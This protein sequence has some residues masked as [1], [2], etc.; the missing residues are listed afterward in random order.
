MESF[1]IVISG[2]TAIGKT[3]VGVRIAQHFGTEIISADS[4][5]IYREMKIG[6]A[7]PD[8]F[9][10]EQ[11]KHHFIH[12]HSISDYYNASKFEEEAL[13]K[14]SEIFRT[15]NVAVVVGG[16]MLYIDALCKGID[17]L[18][19]IDPQ[20][21]KQLIEKFDMEG[22][23]SLRFELKRL[24]PEYYQTV[25]LK[26]P[27]RLLHALEICIMTGK[28]YSSFRTHPC[29]PRPF[30]II[31]IGLNTERSVLY[32]RINKRVDEMV[33]NGLEQEARRLWPFRQ[34]NALNTVGYKEWFACF[35]GQMTRDETID[36]IKSNTRRYARKQ[37]TWFRND[38]GINW[39]DIKNESQIIPFIGNKTSKTGI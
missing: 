10:L 23:E 11:V 13:Q 2:P 9:T 32:E 29:K 36:K 7:V 4:R 27:K 5:Q 3:A 20:V 24:D 21:R 17:D 19:T 16:S 30:V 1:L 26:N 6:T 14:L 8:A 33:E 34:A 35:D 18:P 12:S 31:K 25:D 15:R 38:M 28:P 22:V 39:F 37:L